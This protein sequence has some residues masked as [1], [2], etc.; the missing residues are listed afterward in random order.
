MIKLILEL[1]EMRH[2]NNIN[3]ENARKHRNSKHIFIYSQRKKQKG[4]NAKSFKHIY[5]S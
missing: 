3:I 5:N 4:I 2:H 1:I